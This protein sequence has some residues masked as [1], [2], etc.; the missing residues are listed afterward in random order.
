[1][2]TQVEDI[3]AP[4]RQYVMRTF[5]CQMNAH[6]SERMGKSL[7]EMGYARGAH[8]TDSDAEF[9]ELRANLVLINTCHVREKAAQ[10]FYS[11]L[12]RLERRP[13][14]IIGVAGCVAQVEG[15]ELVRRFPQID[16]VIGTDQLDALPEL[17]YRAQNGEHSIVFNKFDRTQN[18]TLETKFAHGKPRAFVNIMKGCNHFC[19]YCIVPYTRGREKSR[20]MAEIVRDVRRMVELQGVREV[21]LLGQNVN[22]FGKYSGESFPELLRELNKISGLNQIRYTTSHPVDFSQ[23]LQDCYADLEKLERSIHLPV[24]SGSNTVLAKMRREYKREEYLEKVLPFQKRFPDILLS[25]DLIVGFPGESDEDFE[26]SMDLL[27]QVRYGQIY[28]FNYSARAGTRAANLFEDDVPLEVKNKRLSRLLSR[29]M[30]IV[31]QINESSLGKTVRAFVD[32]ESGRSNDGF[33]ARTS[34]NRYV[35]FASGRVFRDGDPVEVKIT[36][37]R[38]N[39]LYGQMV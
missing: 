36:E 29:Q 10:K 1:M 9:A 3:L 7:E 8:Y 25:T 32:L 6:D 14:Q 21:C 26:A 2:E 17:V 28:A 30:E 37:I 27:E 16:F 19:T 18:Y 4:K 39:S 20:P 15:Q 33:T 12:G 38:K 5:G 11:L 34:C 31:Q 13:D 22:S 35:H 23:E 24:Q